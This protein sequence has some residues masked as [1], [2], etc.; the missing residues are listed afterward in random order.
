MMLDDADQS[1]IAPDF[2]RTFFCRSD[3]RQAFTAR[4]D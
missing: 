2:Y 1:I 3:F 4:A